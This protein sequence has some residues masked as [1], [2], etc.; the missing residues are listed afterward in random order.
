M[1][2]TRTI[3][4]VAISLRSIRGN[5]TSTH[6]LASA[7][8]VNEELQEPGCTVV[9]GVDVLLAEV[10]AQLGHHVLEG[11]GVVLE[12]HLQLW[13]ARTEE[14]LGTSSTQVGQEIIP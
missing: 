8:G 6:A 11:A 9:A 13:E 2:C 12:P 10:L 4:T 5:D 1:S 7:Y 3:Y 14:P